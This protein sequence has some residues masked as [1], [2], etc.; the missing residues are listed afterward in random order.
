M[1]VLVA[2]APDD[3]GDAALTR[4]IQEAS[5]RGERLVVV[6]G[7]KSDRMVDP[8]RAADRTWEQV[9][10]EVAASG[11]EHEVRELEGPDVARLI[12]EAA[13]ELEADLLVIGLRRRT[14]VG[15]LV[16]GSIAQQVLLGAPCPVLS[17]R[18]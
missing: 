3:A 7:A 16:L 2:Y 11:V 14:P 13:V 17:I 6:H 1:T 4:G 12:I 10:A 8:W 15:K 9:T 18:P 5:S